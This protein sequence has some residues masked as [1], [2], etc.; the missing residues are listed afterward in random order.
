MAGLPDVGAA[1]GGTPRAARGRRAVRGGRD[2]SGDAGASGGAPDG[3]RVVLVRHGRT[4]WNAEGRWQGHL[5]PELDDTGIA[6]AE[7][8]A[9]LLAAL[10]PDV[11]VSSDLRRAVATVAPLARLTGLPVSYD[12]DVRETFIGAWGGLTGAEVRAKYA[13]DFAVW[14]SGDVHVRPGGGESRVEVAERMCAGI[15]R[16]LPGVPPGGTLLVV[17]HGGAARVGIARLLGLEHAS[18][19]ALGGLSNCSWSLLAQP[20]RLESPRRSWRLLEHNAGSLPEP[21]L[22]E[23]G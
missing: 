9:R 11:I 14:Q 2:L 17:T 21:V 12:A 16:A 4:R 23:E 13:E 20:R 1:G 7:A 18:W 15:D 22:T 3:R 5:D 8:A 10:R 6:Q 19:G